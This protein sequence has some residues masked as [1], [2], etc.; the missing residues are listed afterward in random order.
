MLNGDKWSALSPKLELPVS[1][2][3]A[4]NEPKAALNTVMDNRILNNSIPSVY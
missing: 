1:I 3:Y 2:S 4:M